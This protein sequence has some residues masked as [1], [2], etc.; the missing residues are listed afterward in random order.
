MGDWLNYHQLYYFWVIA[1]E[2]GITPAAARL[3]L[4]ASN[5]S[6]QLKALEDA[7][8]QPLFERKAKRLLLTEA[9]RTAL[10]YAGAIFPQGQELLDLLRN[11][12]VELK[13]HVVRVGVMSPLSKNFQFEFLRP[14]V[15][16]AQVRLQ[17]VEGDLSHLTRELLG[18]NLD[19]VLSNMPVRTDEDH[20]LYNQKLGEMPICLVGAR[21]F[22]RPRSAWPAALQGLPVFV[23]THESKVRNEWDHYCELQ[24]VKPEISAEIE[25]MALLRIFALSGKGC[26]VV[27]EIVVKNEI[28]ARELFVLHRFAGVR[29]TFYAITPFRRSPN[30]WV[31]KLVSGFAAQLSAPGGRRGR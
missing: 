28:A 13:K 18:H 5:L 22:R 31:Q 8:G 6:G 19:V 4:S 17:V 16:L 15:G 23:P 30:P 12:P 7:L 11:R 2:G 21:A 29:E 10:D 9:G 26:A 24:G 27:P 20:G 25:D 14:L 3:R 1:K